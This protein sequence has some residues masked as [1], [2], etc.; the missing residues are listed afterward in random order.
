V[1]AGRVLEL[2]WRPQAEEPSLV[3]IELSPDGGG[4]KLVLDHR[5]IAASLGMRYVR[6]WTA[7]L[8][9]VAP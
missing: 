8:A 1:E 5:R 7:R 6:I 4:T 3:R 9:R 2:D